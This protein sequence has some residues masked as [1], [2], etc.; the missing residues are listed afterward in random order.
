M[1]TQTQKVFTS[2]ISPRLI[3]WVNERAKKKQVTHRAILE[4]ALVGYQQDV[5]RKTLRE[6]FARAS[7]DPDIVELAEWGMD[8]YANVVGST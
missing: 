2:T 3:A 1:K 8:D 6:G 7:H 5:R 4:E